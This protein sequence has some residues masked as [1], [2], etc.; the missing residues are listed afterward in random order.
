MNLFSRV[1]LESES[2]QMSLPKILKSLGVPL[3]SF[4]LLGCH[5]KPRN[6]VLN[7]GAGAEAVVSGGAIPT[8]DPSPFA[9]VE[10]GPHQR[11]WSWNETD[12]AG[13][14]NP[15]SYTE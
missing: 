5:S 13:R 15:H 6:S 8:P 14:T 2:S 9:I 10:S 4:L 1:T 3:L 7:E 12:E 11:V